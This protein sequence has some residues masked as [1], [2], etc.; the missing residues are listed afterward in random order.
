M[1]LFARIDKTYIWYVYT[2]LI[3]YGFYIESIYIYI[4]VQLI[5]YWYAYPPSLWNIC[6]HHPPHDTFHSLVGF[7]AGWNGTGSFCRHLVN[8]KDRHWWVGQW[9][10]IR[11]SNTNTPH[12]EED[13]LEFLLWS[14]RIGHLGVYLW[15]R[16]IQYLWAYVGIVL[17]CK[18]CGHGSEFK[19]ILFWI[20]PE[21]HQAP[22]SGSCIF[23][24]DLAQ[25]PLLWS[26][27]TFLVGRNVRPSWDSTS[28]LVTE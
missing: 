24:H 28:L 25:P 1:Y 27:K 16:K 7:R 14:V 12:S 20:M 3:L 26:A 10:W 9:W 15:S 17:I 5:L 11:I 22:Q 18:R 8:D 21:P 2:Y 13:L 4:Y 6:F 19:A 23:R